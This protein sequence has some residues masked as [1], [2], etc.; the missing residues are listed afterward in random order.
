MSETDSSP[1]G[2][3]STLSLILLES[4]LGVSGSTTIFS[5]FSESDSLRSFLGEVGER[6]GDVKAVVVYVNQENDSQT[7]IIHL[8]NE[9]QPV[10][11]FPPL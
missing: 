7:Y 8:K 2:L 1:L 10:P 4:S 5:S 6:R 9:L 3:S 11:S